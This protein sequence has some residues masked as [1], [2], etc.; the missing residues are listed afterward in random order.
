MRKITDKVFDRL[1]EDTQNQKR[2]KEALKFEEV[3][4]A[5]LC[6]YKYTADPNPFLSA[7]L[8]SCEFLLDVP[9]WFLFSLSAVTSTSTC[10]G[11]T[12]I[13]HPRRGSRNS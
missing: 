8:C 4:I 1:T 5:V 11:R 6:V 7:S 9:D 13:P 10:R 3:Y 12:T 2:E